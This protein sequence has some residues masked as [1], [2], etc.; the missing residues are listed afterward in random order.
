MLDTNIVTALLKNDHGVRERLSEVS[1][2]D[3]CISVITLAEMHYGLYKHPS[4][5][6][7]ALVD[8]FLKTVQALPWTERVA[9]AYGSMRANQEKI[10]CVLAPL[11]LQI[12]A[13]AKAENCL[14]VT[15]DR[16][17]SRVADLTVINWAEKP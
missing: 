11:D 14:L 15:D 3:V 12:A 9:D 16:A 5:K 6:R 1:N 8:G 13:H 4:K 10:G 17:F 7:R 2:H